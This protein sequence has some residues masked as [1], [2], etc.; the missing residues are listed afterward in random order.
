MKVTNTV[1]FLKAGDRIKAAIA[2]YGLTA[3]QKMEREAKKNRPWTDRTSNAKN[4]IQGEFKMGLGSAKIFLSG[5]VD[6]F[7]KLE[8]AYEKRYAI[9]NPTMQAMAPDIISGYQK[10]LNSL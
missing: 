6:Y 9:L 3:A 10:V 4:S 1:D 5:N 7:V 8:Y 2:V